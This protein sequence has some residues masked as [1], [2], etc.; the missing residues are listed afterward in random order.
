MSVHR[1]HELLALFPCDRC[2]WAPEDCPCRKGVPASPPPVGKPAR[3]PRVLTLDER[4][5]AYTS[6]PALDVIAAV[7]AERAGDRKDGVA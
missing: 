2:G 3:Q 7:A 5:A 6:L 1:W 4:R